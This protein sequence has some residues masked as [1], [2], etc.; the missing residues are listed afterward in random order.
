M[1]RLLDATR[2][3]RRQVFVEAARRRAAVEGWAAIT[4]DEV[5][6]EAGMSKGAFYS[7]FASKQAL[8]HALIEE[9]AAEVGGVLGRLE[10]Q[11]PDPADRLEPLARAMLTRASDPSRAQLLADL[12]ATV[13]SDAELRRRV[14]RANREHRA[15]IRGWIE[16]ALAAGEIVSVPAN[17]LASILLA[18][19]DGLL[20]HRTLDE[21]SFRWVNIGRALEALL[22]GLRTR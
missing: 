18:L 19:N 6:G 20:L 14:N 9:D 1:P 22:R 2:R 8:L 11:H 3:E 4:V 15:I 17:A 12:W 10:A 21:A 13:S 7:H 5:C 16:E